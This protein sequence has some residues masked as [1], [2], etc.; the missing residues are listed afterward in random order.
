MTF[1]GCRVVLLTAIAQL[2]IAQAAWG[3]VDLGSAVELDP[4]EAS[5]ATSY[6]GFNR[7][8]GQTQYR[9]TVTNISSLSFNGTVYLVIDSID[10]PVT[11]ANAD[12]TTTTGD[13]VFSIISGTLAPG[14][15]V[16]PVSL[17]F[18][19]SGSRAPRFT[20][21]TSVFLVP[22]SICSVG[23]ACDTG[24]VGICS[25]GTVACPDGPLG[26]EVCEQTNDPVIEICG[27]GLDND[28]DG[29][30]DDADVCTPPTCTAAVACETGEF[31][32]CSAGLTACPDGP[33]G[34]PVCERTNDP[35]AEIC[36]D[37]LDNDCDG[38]TDDADVCIQ[39]CFVGVFCETGETGVCSRGETTCPG[40]PSGAP[41]C[42]RLTNPS[43]ET[44]DS[45]DNNCD[46]SV[47]EGFDVG[48]QCDTGN[49]GICAP[50]A[51]ACDGSG[52]TQ[53]IANSGPQPEICND[54]IDQDC[55]GSD[56]VL[57]SLDIQL[58]VAN[59]VTA[60]DSID[61]TGRLPSFFRLPVK[62]RE[63]CR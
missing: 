50:G 53:C 54:G 4:S 24:E 1:G 57:L 33:S 29:E 12:D 37:G 10:G 36:G 22:D 59:F 46:G 19:A 52:G 13:P 39:T 7:R 3:T 8:N 47:D 28:C 63:R 20:F 56:C 32:I 55:D 16:G 26:A 9:A 30:V 25:A 43:P 40:G 60:A 48:S 21:T 5:V 58:P 11:V 2:A 38:E 49:T 44:C 45:L 62:G 34:A 17:L 27:D 15:S 61:V 51:L 23:N 14:E 6:A 42:Q 18:Q 35:V 41:F 31:G